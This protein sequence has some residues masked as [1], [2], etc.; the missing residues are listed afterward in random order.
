VVGPLSPNNKSAH[1]TLKKYLSQYA[2][3]DIHGL[4][5]SLFWNE[6]NGMA[7]IDALLVLPIYDEPWEQLRSFLTPPDSDKSIVMIW[8][9]NCPNVEKTEVSEAAY[10]RTNEALE[11][12]KS[13]Y[14]FEPLSQ[15]VSV[16]SVSQNVRLYL[17]ERCQHGALIPE[18]Q[19]VGLARKLGLDLAL[20]LCDKQLDAGMNAPA[21][22]HC[23]DADVRLPIGYFEIP[24]PEK[25]QV[26]SLY[27]FKHIASPGYEQAMALYDFRLQ[28][29]E[30]QLAQA[31]SPY[32]F[33]TVGS[34]IAVTPLAYAQV[35]GM[36][37]RSGGEDFYF[38]NKLAKIGRVVS[39]AA[40]ELEVAGR[41]SCRVPIGTGPAIQGIREYV[42]PLNDY[43]YYHPEIFVRLRVLHEC[44][45]TLDVDVNREGFSVCLNSLIDQNRAQLIFTALESLGLERFFKHLQG[46]G[47][48]QSFKKLFDIWFDGFLTLKFVHAMRDFDCPSLSIMGLREHSGLL[49][50]DLLDR[51]DGLLKSQNVRD[52]K[53]RE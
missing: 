39:L 12:L 1:R 41:P 38:L 15:R 22:L 9:F 3:P 10:S 18:K 4:P 31:H 53:L 42:D 43:L 45:Q 21:W 23:S 11:A 47:H 49:S 44:V 48:R 40:P 36:P 27:P 51:V 13:A 24:S 25:D 34:I 33:Q 32:A 20:S 29:Y 28:Y 30:A 7:A 52:G 6:G 19:G 16:T 8:V 50:D 26:V 46:Q 14:S 17:L 5:Q 2:E 37:K 35:R